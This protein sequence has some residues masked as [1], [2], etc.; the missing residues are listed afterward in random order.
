MA[1]ESPGYGIGRQSSFMDHAN[2]GQ[3]VPGM[4]VFALGEFSRTQTSPSRPHVHQLPVGEG[5]VVWV[6]ETATVERLFEAL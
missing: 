1:A 6:V 5:H 3:V 2:G 4:L